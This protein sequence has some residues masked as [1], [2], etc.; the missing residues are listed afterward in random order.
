[1]GVPLRAKQ[2][3]GRNVRETDGASV[4]V[5]LLGLVLTSS[6]AAALVGKLIDRGS[7]HVDRLREGYAEAAKALAEWSNFPYRIERRV[8]DDAETRKA[9]AELGSDITDRLAYYSGWISADSPEMGEFYIRL[10]TR[11]RADVAE[12]VRYAWNQSPRSTG[13]EMNIRKKSADSTPVRIISGWAYVQLFSTAVR[14]RFGWR[15]HLVWGPLLRR[16]LLTRETEAG[17][18]LARVRREVAPLLEPKQRTSAQGSQRL[19]SRQDPENARND[20]TVDT[21]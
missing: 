1:M 4:W 6:V 20:Q 7:T 21:A 10:V 14:Y 17:V 2:P 3:G 5:V 11:L 16:L 8:A 15:R 19:P 13:S 12:H 9:L 18:A